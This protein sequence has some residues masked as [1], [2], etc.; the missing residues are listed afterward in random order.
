M[1]EYVRANGAASRVERTRESLGGTIGQN[2][3]NS[4]LSNERLRLGARGDNTAYNQNFSAQWDWMFVRPYISVEPSI[5]LGTVQTS[6]NV[7]C[8]FGVGIHNFNVVDVAGCNNALSPNVSQPS[9]A[10]SVSFAMYE[11][12]CYVVD[13]EIDLTVAGGTQLASAPTPAY[14]YT[15]AGPGGY[16]ASTEDLIGVGAGVYNVTVADDNACAVNGSTTL[17][18]LVPLN[19]PGYTWTGNTNALWQEVGN[20]D[21]R[22]PDATSEVV[23][24]GA[25]I[26]GNNPVIQIGITGNAFD[27]DIQGSTVD[28]L[29]IQDGGLLIIHKP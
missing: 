13:G 6:D 21:C 28:L 10:L 11:Q 26:G 20:W 16:S 25:P 7:F 17:N 19:S 2:Y 5:A 23:I 1:R 12:G 18:Q 27:I 22:L 14:Y 4:G 3:N 15:W 8:G 29:D 9:A 24:P